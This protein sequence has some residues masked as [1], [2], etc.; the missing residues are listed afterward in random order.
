MYASKFTRRY[1]LAHYVIVLVTTFLV[2]AFGQSMGRP[3]L[4]LTC[5]S[6]VLA[7]ASLG[8]LLEHKGWAPIL[9]AVRL[10][11]GGIAIALFVMARVS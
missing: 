2:M 5:A 8:G 4:Y 7:L 3:V 9:E 10:M 6:I 11:V 1:V